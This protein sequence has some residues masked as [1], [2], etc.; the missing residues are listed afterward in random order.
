MA[1]LDESSLQALDECQSDFDEGLEQKKEEEEG[2]AEFEEY[3]SKYGQHIHIHDNNL[4]GDDGFVNRQLAAFHAPV[5]LA[6][7]S[8]FVAFPRKKETIND[9]PGT[10]H[11]HPLRAIA[12]VLHEAVPGSI[13]RV[14]AYSL[15]DLAAIDLLVHAG[16][17]NTVR[18]LLQQR[19][20]DTQRALNRWVTEVGNK[21]LLLENLEIRLVSVETLGANSSQASLHMTAIITTTRT[22]TGSYNL[23]NL[24]RS[25]NLELLTVSPTEHR[26]VETFDD[27]WI[28]DI[29]LTNQVEKIYTELQY[30]ACPNSR[31]KRRYDEVREEVN[32]RTNRRRADESRT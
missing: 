12:A 18:I 19:S 25:G 29:I 28:R 2:E 7:K 10:P 30:P 11:D 8:L 23:S 4:V 5:D 32:R 17:T 1:S 31:R 22:V 20:N 16:K 27:I 3:V 26:L 15:T 14:F 6:T 21:M 9:L 24:A 13:I